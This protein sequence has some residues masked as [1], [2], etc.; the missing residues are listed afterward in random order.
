MVR[1]G[2]IELD[3][4]EELGN[5]GWSWDNLLQYMKKVRFVCTRNVYD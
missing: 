1:P 4:L 3:A 5:P 2:K